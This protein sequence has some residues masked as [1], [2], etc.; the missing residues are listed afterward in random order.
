MLSPQLLGYDVRLD[1][2][3]YVSQLWS[4]DFRDSLLLK[5]NVE[6]PLS[7]SWYVWP[8][9]FLPRSRLELQASGEEVAPSF[10]L[11][12]AIVVDL[13]ETR[14]LALNLWGS[15]SA[16]LESYRRQ[17]RDAARGVV[18]AVWL[19][20]FLP[21]GHPQLEGVLDPAVVPNIVRDDWLFLGYDVTDEFMDSALAGLALPPE[22]RLHLRASVSPKLNQYGLFSSRED[23]L[24]FEATAERLALNPRS[25][26]VCGLYRLPL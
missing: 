19:E 5:T 20:H 11:E 10:V 13:E 1:H 23:A 26:C 17:K 24:E 25:F 2:S 4:R 18:I 14:Y 3:V 15:L 8:S 6:W 16:M 21:V 12:R 9:Y 7:V 22:D